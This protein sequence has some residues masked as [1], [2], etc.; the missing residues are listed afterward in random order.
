MR[1]RRTFGALILGLAVVLAVL[2]PGRLALA[3]DIGVV[4]LHG[5]GGMPNGLVKPLA[6]YLEREG[7]AVANLEMPWS[8]HREYGASPE[9][10]VAEIG[11]AF[12]AMKESGVTRIFVAGHSLGALFAAHYAAERPVTGLVLIAPGGNVASDFWQKKVALSLAEADGMI[13]AGKGDEVGDF[14]DFEGSKGDFTIR[15]TPRHYKAWFSTQSPLNQVRAYD[16]L[17][18]GLPVLNVV[19]VNDYKGLLRGKHARFRQLPPTPMLEMYEPDTDHKSAPDVAAEKIAAW[20]RA[21][22]AH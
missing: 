15:T 9:D 7:F 8:K 4:V 16:R 14:A 11:A 20:I 2:L 10:G 22:A 18:S 3:A 6:A 1:R 19:P 21:V 17:P 13:E 12:A 5:K